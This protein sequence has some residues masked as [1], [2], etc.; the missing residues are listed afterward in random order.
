MFL[1][2]FHNLSAGSLFGHL[3]LLFSNIFSLVESEFNKFKICGVG[4][5]PEIKCYFYSFYGAEVFEFLIM[6]TMCLNGVFCVL[7]LASVCL[8]S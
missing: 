4:R 5:L 1:A 8:G 2:T 7:R 3:L 6:V